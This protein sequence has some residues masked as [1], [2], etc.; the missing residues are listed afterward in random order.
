[1]IAVGRSIV[2]CIVRSFCNDYSVFSGNPTKPPFRDF[3]IKSIGVNRA[4]LRNL[5]DLTGQQIFRR[6]AVIGPA[7]AAVRREMSQRICL[8]VTQRR[9][10]YDEAGFNEPR[11][12]KGPSATMP[13]KD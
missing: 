8:Q 11:L 9:R 3:Q 10:R 12:L 7:T 4:S 13:E 1:M 5:F 6:S 2:S